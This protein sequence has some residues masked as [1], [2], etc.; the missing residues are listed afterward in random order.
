MRAM[1]DRTMSR[2]S[3]VAGCCAVF[4]A[5]LAA[6]A[7]S[8]AKTS[9]IG[10]LAALR[11]PALD[12]ESAL[13]SALRS[14]GYVE[15][16]NLAI[17]WRWADGTTE[18]LDAL[19]ADL[20][21][22]NVEVIVAL[23]ADA[24]ASARRATTT[25]PIVMVAARNPVETGLVQSLARPGGNVTGTT[26]TLPETAGKV[27]EVLKEAVP[28]AKRVTI[29]W[30]PDTPG[31]GLYK[32]HADR[33]AER[34]GV[35]LTYVG[36]RESEAFSRDRVVR[37][38]PDALYVVPDP[39]VARHNEAIA[40]FAAERKLPSI[41]TGK[42]F[43]EAGGLLYFGPD[44]RDTWRLTAAYVDRILKGGRPA[45]LP[46]EQPSKFEL[47]VNSRTAK[48]IGITMPPVL[49]GRVDAFIE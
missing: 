34:L 38:R 32:P 44:W 43:V 14:L 16:Q 47:V 1:I 20:V 23:L 26:Y 40:R 5:P 27:V 3:L 4:A 7:Q 29:L 39:V 33:A 42:S 2:R 19:A 37:S 8:S 46:V 41:G 17:E 6:G 28:R 13:P 24:A 30:N 18:R 12:V 10:V 36:I 48:A 22:A 35:R 15:R 25:I 21:R 45:D 9:T 49:L 11:Q 31:M